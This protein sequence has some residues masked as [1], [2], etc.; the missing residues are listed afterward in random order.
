MLSRVMQYGGRLAP[1]MT[2]A[3][4]LRWTGVAAKTASL[5]WATSS[6][7]K[8]NNDSA[9]VDIVKRKRGR[10]KKV[11]T[12]ESTNNTDTVI[13]T[14]ATV[15][16]QV[17]MVEEV[18]A[19][20]RSGRPKKK[21]LTEQATTDPT[22]KGSTD[23]VD[24]PTE[25]TATTP[26]KRMNRKKAIIASSDTINDATITVNNGVKVAVKAKRTRKPKVSSTQLPTTSVIDTQPSSTSSPSLISPY[27]ADSDRWMNEIL[28]TELSVPTTIISSVIKLFDEGST[29]PFIARYRKEMSGGM[30]EVK[31]ELLQKRIGQLR[32]LRDRRT[33]I[34]DAMTERK[35]LTDEIKAQVLHSCCQW[36]WHH[37]IVGSDK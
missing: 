5:R 31:V 35:Q 14:P 24:T 8:E 32:A 29:V 12:E 36:S 28:A 20:S 9:S 22:S 10:P 33:S 3:P 2:A 15:L 21:A 11:P 13:P 18:K 26:K 37:P 16:Q 17:T 19:K 1:T 23:I 34:I 7:T 25:A 4:L 30:D 6:S 27:K